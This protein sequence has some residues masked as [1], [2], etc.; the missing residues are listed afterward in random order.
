M[1][2]VLITGG[3]GFIGR[4]LAKRCIEAGHTVCIVDNLSVGRLEN[5]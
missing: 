4:W 1:H 5:L 3:A 2:S